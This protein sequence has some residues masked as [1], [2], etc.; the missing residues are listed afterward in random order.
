MIHE[1]DTSLL[2]DWDNSKLY[3]NVTIEPYRTLCTVVM[4]DL[5]VSTEVLSNVVFAD[6]NSTIF[7]VDIGDAEIHVDMRAD[8]RVFATAHE[9]YAGKKP[10]VGGVIK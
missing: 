8:G 10:L 9:G 5:P 2:P 1:V 6:Q 4:G 3:V 7:S